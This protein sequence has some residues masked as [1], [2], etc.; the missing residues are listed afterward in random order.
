M[1]LFSSTD[2]LRAVFCCLPSVRLAHS[3]STDSLSDPSTGAEREWYAQSRP[4]GGGAWDDTAERFGRDVDALSLHEG[5]MGGGEDDFQQLQRRRRI[6]GRGGDACGGGADT[7]SGLTR[8]SLLK[9]WWRGG[10]GA[11]RL[12]DSEDEGEEAGGADEDEP[13]AGGLR[14]SVLRGE[15]DGDEDAVPLSLED[16]VV[17]PAP[18]SSAS[19]GLPPSSPFSLADTPTSPVLSEGTTLVDPDSNE[20]REERRA[21]LRARR[22]ARELG[23]SVEEFEQGVAAGE[24]DE[25]AGGEAAAASSSFLDVAGARK[26]GKSSSRGSER[27]H[28]GSSAS[29]G[30]RDREYRRKDERRRELSVVE[31]DA[32]LAADHERE[33]HR[34]RSR[35]HR[36]DERDEDTASSHGGSSRSSRHDFPSGDA[37]LVAL[38]VSPSASSAPSSSR[39]SKHRSHPSVSSTSTSSHSH[40][41]TPSHSHSHSSS[42]RSSRRKDRSRTHL[43]GDGDGHGGDYLA[44]AFS[45]LDDGALPAGQQLYYQDE[46]GQL[47]PYP[48]AHLAYPSYSDDGTSA[49]AGDAQQVY[50]VA[51][52][53][54]SLTPAQVDLPPSGEAPVSPSYEHI[55]VLPPPSSA[56]SMRGKVERVSAGADV[57]REEEG[58]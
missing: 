23:I 54:G 30:S 1:D 2:R 55:G 6:G 26:R 27:S 50:L 48:A 9:S 16:V 5:V 13:A 10:G 56:A 32:S 18:P 17:P 19:H 12:P 33:P 21:R 25:L 51:A 53:D 22:R 52:E 4:I 11:I 46:H 14:R 45:P 15:H 34:S 42:H 44:P 58:W 31:E 20:T 29:S 47:Q 36:Y 37:H 38:P 24:P 43:T 35:R 7:G 49:S 28:T 3:P 41:H 8:W 57:G 39:R 40:S